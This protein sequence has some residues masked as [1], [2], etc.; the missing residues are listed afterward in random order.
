MVHFVGKKRKERTAVSNTD[1]TQGLSCL[2]AVC[3]GWKTLG[4]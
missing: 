1:R 3:K 2:L 4:E